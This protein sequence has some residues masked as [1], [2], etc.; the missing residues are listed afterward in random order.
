ML[1]ISF[2]FD[3]VSNKVS[4]V[5]VITTTTQKAS[6]K[7]FDLEVEENKLTLTSE[8]IDKLGAVAGDRISVNYWT[9]DSET[10]YPIISKSDVFTDGADGNKLTQKGTVSFKGQQRIS[11]LKFGNL[12]EFSQFIDKAGKVRDDVFKLVPVKDD[13]LSDDAKIFSDEQEITKELDASRV[14]DEIDTILGEENYE[15]VLPF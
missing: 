8:A 2:D 5:K 15:D 7:K 12:F 4:N 10:T 13:R 9:V 3:E 6:T 1:K 11:L 14:E